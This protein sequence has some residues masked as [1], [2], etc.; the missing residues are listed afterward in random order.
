MP[1]ASICAGYD[2]SILFD[3]EN[4]PENKEE[5]V[6]KAGLLKRNCFASVFEKYFQ[7]QQEGQEGKERAVI[8]YRDD[9]TM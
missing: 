8:N 3:L 6:K 7:F 2:V 1:L 9:E 4:V 5:A